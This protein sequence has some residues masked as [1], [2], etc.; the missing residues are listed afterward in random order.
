MSAGPSSLPSGAARVLAACDGLLREVGRWEHRF[1]WLRDPQAPSDEWL[2]VDGYY[3]A[4]KLVVYCGEDP[5]ERRLYEQLVPQHG[6][7]LLA[8][9][10]DE[11]PDDQ[12]AAQA[13]VRTQL[14]KDGWSPRPVSRPVAAVPTPAP[15][16]EAKP[17]HWTQVHTEAPPPQST[18]A[19]FG[20]GLA[21]SL[22]VLVEAYLGFVVL[23]IDKGD[24]V[25]GLGLLLDAAARALGTLSARQ[26]QHP[27]QTWPSLLIGSPE[28]ARQE[29]PGQ[30]VAIAALA[31]IALGILLAIL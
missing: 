16:R 28:V 23:A 30:A 19:G 1:A 5:E 2:V 24:V 8:V 13:V 6:L 10:P 17:G 22:M 20:I 21:L 11:L 29:Q 4:N 25:L 9:K 26:R 27:E 18:T 31:L 14:E 3:P 15:A 7:Y 12:L